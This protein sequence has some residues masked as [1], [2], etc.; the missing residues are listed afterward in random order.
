MLIDRL[1]NFY[2]SGYQKIEPLGKFT[3]PNLYLSIFLL[4]PR[5]NEKMIGSYI[6]I[7]PMGRFYQRQGILNKNLFSSPIVRV[8]TKQALEQVTFDQSKF[9]QRYIPLE[10]AA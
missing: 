8:G 4:S 2:K 6:M 1:Q 9:N 3:S 5:D 7:D 10:I